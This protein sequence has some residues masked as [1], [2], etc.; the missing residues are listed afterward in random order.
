M[1]LIWTEPAFQDLDAI[2]DYIALDK[3]L[4][5]KNLVK[6]VF[7]S[8]NYLRQHPKMGSCPRELPRS[9]YFQL[10]VSPCRIFYRIKDNLVFILY[11]MREEQLFKKWILKE[12]G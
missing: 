1:E 5:A 6:K 8:V 12:R 2:A 9:P 11:V 7:S 10:I 3:P 4:A